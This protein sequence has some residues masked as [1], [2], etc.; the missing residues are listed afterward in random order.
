MS[1]TSIFSKTFSQNHAATPLFLALQ[2]VQ[3]RCVSQCDSLVC[4][5]RSV[6]ERAWLT[7]WVEQCSTPFTNSPSV[8]SAYRHTPSKLHAVNSPQT[9]SSNTHRTDSK[10]SH[11]PLSRPT[12]YDRHATAAHAAKLF[13][14]IFRRATPRTLSLF[15]LPVAAAASHNTRTTP[16]AGISKVDTRKMHSKLVIIG[17]VQNQRTW[18]KCMETY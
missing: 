18:S 1:S 11:I 8:A 16:L 17:Y 9:R 5:T 10:T 2:T 12:C 4:K 3:S 13:A 15:S 6:E 14:S 7:S